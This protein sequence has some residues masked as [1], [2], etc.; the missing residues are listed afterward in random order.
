M[1]PSQAAT[2]SPGDSPTRDAAGSPHA[3]SLA[4]SE[5]RPRAIRTV[6]DAGRYLGEV[7]AGCVNFF[8]PG[9]I[10]IGGDISEAQPQL[11]AGVREVIFGRSLPFATGDLR[12]VPCQLGDRAG[13]IGAA[14]MVLEHVLRA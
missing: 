12:I 13:A 10:V 5:R 14:I 1:R 9:A 11:L 3:T 7:L 6:R 2:R 8:N 4:S